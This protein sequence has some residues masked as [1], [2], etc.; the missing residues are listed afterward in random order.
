MRDEDPFGLFVRLHNEALF[1]SA[2]L[3][4]GSS[5]HAEELLQ[6]TL[7]T[8]YPRWAR[9]AAADSPVAYVR[10]SLANRYVSVHRRRSNRDV[11]LSELPEQG[12]G[13]DLAS[14]VADRQLLWQ[15]LRTL[16]PRQRA[17]LV[18][19]YFHDMPD[20]E[21]AEALGCRVATVRSLVSRGVAAMRGALDSASTP[22]AAPPG[23]SETTALEGQYDDRSS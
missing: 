11:T 3:L 12:E 5:T 8:L 17:A 16:P 1:R 10:R 13:R 6:D 15:L 18:L 2:Y 23:R 19:R 7:T 22:H 14:D 20:G 9:V 4:T 21:I